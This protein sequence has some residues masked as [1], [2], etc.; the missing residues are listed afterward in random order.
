MIEAQASFLRSHHAPFSAMV[1]EAVATHIGLATQCAAIFATWPGD[2]RAAALPLRLLAGLHHV[3]RAGVVPE[4]SSAFAS[5]DIDCEAAVAKA[6]VRC[7]AM[8]AGWLSSPTQTNEVA[9]SA[10]TMAALRVLAGRFDRPIALFE[11][12]ASAGLNLV[13]D[14]YAFDLGGVQGGDPAS[15]LELKPAWDGPAPVGAQPRIV[16]AQGIDQDP[17]DIRSAADCERL[18][19]YVWPDRR[20]RLWI[21]RQAIGLARNRR[22]DL[23]RGDAVT[24]L[25]DQLKAPADV[26]VTRCIVHTMFEQYLGPADKARIAAVLDSTGAKATSDAPLARISFEWDASRTRVE[27]ALTVWPDGVRQVLAHCH[28]YGAWIRWLGTR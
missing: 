25:C 1:M 22:V 26:G 23:Q 8:L 15:P 28:P 3:A 16:R 20:D 6:L 18:F 21:L 10:A 24:W 2:R 17:L 4:L 5:L 9:R 27:L 13:L 7:D 19:A 14:A 11:L 12:G